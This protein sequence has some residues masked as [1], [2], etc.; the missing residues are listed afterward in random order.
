MMKICENC[1]DLTETVTICPSCGWSP[2]APNPVG[3]NIAALR[4]EVESYQIAIRQ[5]LSIGKC[6]RE[7]EDLPERFVRSQGESIMAICHTIL[8]EGE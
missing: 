2:N 1:G 6:L 5:V 3:K 4:A 8:K 7:R